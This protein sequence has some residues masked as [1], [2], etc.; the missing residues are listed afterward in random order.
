[1]FVTNSDKELERMQSVQMKID[2]G[3]HTPIKLMPYPTPI[4]NRKFVEAFV[5]E[6]EAKVS[7]YSKSPWSFLMVVVDKID[8]EHCFC[9]V[10]RALNNITKHLV[11]S[12]TINRRHTGP[13][14]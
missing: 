12:P 5:K 9:T 11:Y 3:N 4:H 14:G 1:M 13:F 8:G 2:M 6:M 7:D 10:F